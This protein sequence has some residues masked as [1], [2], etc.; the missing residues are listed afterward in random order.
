MIVRWPDPHPSHAFYGGACLGCVCSTT[1]SAAEAPCVDPANP[2]EPR[3][4][5]AFDFGG[6]ARP[7]LAGVALEMLAEA[8]L[9]L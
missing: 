7:G 8:G 2:L 4:Y 5:L 6:H 1:G 9:A 3:L